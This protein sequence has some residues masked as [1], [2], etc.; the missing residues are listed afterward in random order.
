M[1]NGKYRVLIVGTH[2]VQY[3]A[4]QFR[5]LTNHPRIDLLVA[6]CSMQ[7]ANGGMDADFGVKVAWDI[8]L[9]EGYSWIEVKNRSLRPGFDRFWGFWNPGLWKLVRKGEFDAVIIFSGYRSASS[10]IAGAAAR[11]GHAAILFG[12]DA[13]DLRPRDGRQWKFRLKKFFWPQFFRLPDVTLVPSSRGVALMNSLGLP[14]DRVV[15]TNYT[16]DNQWWRERAAATDR[17][18]TR[19]TW[20]IPP[21]APVILFCAKLQP[22]KRPGDL[23]RAFARASLSNAFL[24]FAGDGALREKL[25]AESQKLGIRERVRFLGFLN[26]SQLPSAYCACDLLVLPSEYEPFGVVVMEAMLCGCAIIASDRVGAGYDLVR[27]GEN[28]FRFPCGD[29][30]ALAALLRESLA[31][32]NALARMGEVSRRIMDSW[33]PERNTEATVE[34]IVRAVER[35]GA[36][37]RVGRA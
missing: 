31:D 30:D 23:L 8:P 15:L 27:E 7:G 25:E 36:I 3:S 16:V 14:A 21:E 18:Q 35:R 1:N 28:G 37:E 11:A 17:V 4:H 19:K 24:V 2:P 29:V 6:F 20:N 9:L 32:R 13:H 12:T 33:T 34:A 26:Q 5:R 22:W 10:W